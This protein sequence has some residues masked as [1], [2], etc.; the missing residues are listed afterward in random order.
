MTISNQCRRVVITGLGV[1]SSIGIGKESFWNG[2][3]AGRSGIKP[4]TSFDASTFSSRIAG[5]IRDFDAANFFSHEVVRRIDRFGLM[6]LTAV[7]EAVADADLPAKLD[8]LGNQVSV[9]DRKSVV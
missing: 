7:K 6:G 1:L 5:E 2:L 3:K 8:D 9:I 4:I